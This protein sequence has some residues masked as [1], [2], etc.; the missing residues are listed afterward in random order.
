VLPD[1]LPA[2]D[3]VSRC[4]LDPALR[5][6]ILTEQLQPLWFGTPAGPA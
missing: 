6:R 5:R 1:L 3:T 2:G 4:H